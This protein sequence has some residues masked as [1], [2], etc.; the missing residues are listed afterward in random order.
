[1]YNNEV[2]R[3]LNASWT[4]EKREEVET[5]CNV[6]QSFT[7]KSEDKHLAAALGGVELIK[8]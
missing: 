3:K 4:Q 8:K 7:S 1:M 2:K 6:T 5:K